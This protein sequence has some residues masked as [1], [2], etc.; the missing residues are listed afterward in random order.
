MEQKGL[1]QSERW[2][3]GIKFGRVPSRDL[4]Y[5]SRHSR[6]N[7]PSR[8]AAVQVPQ[9]TGSAHTPQ[10]DGGHTGGPPAPMG[11]KSVGSG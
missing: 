9:A 11:A 7:R 6:N 1:N 8:H 4:F 5:G 2:R 10:L 3:G